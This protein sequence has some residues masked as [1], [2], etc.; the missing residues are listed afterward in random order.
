M[1]LSLAFLSLPGDQHPRA[2]SSARYAADDNRVH[3][4]L[5]DHE[6]KNNLTTKFAQSPQGFHCPAAL[7]AMKEKILAQGEGLGLYRQN[8]AE[9][10]KPSK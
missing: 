3:C 2:P 1:L 9:G 8:P 6:A 5:P 7:D 4:G 10:A